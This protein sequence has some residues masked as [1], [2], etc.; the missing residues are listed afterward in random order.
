[1]TQ[2]MLAES[3]LPASVHLAVG[4]F[5]AAVSAASGYGILKALNW[6]R[7]LYLGW[8]IFALV[9]AFFT[10]PFTTVLLLSLVVIAIFGFFLFRP[11]ANDW[12][13]AGAQIASE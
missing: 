2:Q 8:S 3:P 7:Y 4:L 5:G 6:S 13:A 10:S 11:A 9:F 1:M 12:F